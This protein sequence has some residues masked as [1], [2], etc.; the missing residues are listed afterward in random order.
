MHES[1][2]GEVETWL[3]LLDGGF[4]PVQELSGAEARALVAARAQPIDNLDDADAEDREI[5]G[6][7]GPIRVRIYRP[8]SAATSNNSET[9][10]G[11]TRPGVLF[12]HGGGF[13]L[14]SI[15]SHDGFCRRVARH[16]D[17]VVVSVDYRLAPEHEAP[18]AAED[19]YAALTWLAE[20]T[21]EL[22]ID[23]ARLL[24]AGDSAGGNLAAVV[25]LM[26]RDRRGPALAA[27][28]LLYPCLAPDFTTASYRDYG[29]EHFNTQAAMEWYWR[30]YLGA[31]ASATF[32]QGL[33]YPVQLVAP[34]LAEDLSGLP[35]AIV[36]TAGRDPLCDEARTYVTALREAGVSTRHRHYPEL[37][38]GFITIGALGP[39]AAAR[40]LLWSDI[41]ALIGAPTDVPPRSNA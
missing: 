35:P 4:P 22:G 6:P 36:V 30:S 7:A 11:T 32:P 17:A 28:V 8:R 39:A 33:A 12:L 9:T 1:V 20:H 10:A 18:A 26:A 16:L 15:D 38:H 24:T 19:S 14:C 40:D 25:A 3:A 21:G 27:Q 34:P 5:P 31:Q 29:V 23:P 2:A 37:F 41:G 13:V